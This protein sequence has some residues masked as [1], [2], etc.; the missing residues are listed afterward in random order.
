MNGEKMNQRKLC[1]WI[2]LMHHVQ[3]IL[4]LGSIPG[5]I[6]V[7]PDY[8]LTNIETA[9]V[10][11]W[12]IRIVA[13]LRKGMNTDDVGKRWDFL[14]ANIV[15]KWRFYAMPHALLANLGSNRPKRPY[16]PNPGENKDVLQKVLRIL[17]EGKDGTLPRLFAVNVEDGYEFSRRKK[18]VNPSKSK[19][20]GKQPA[21]KEKVKDDAAP[22]TK[23]KVGRGKKNARSPVPS[24]T[25]PE[26]GN[27]QYVNLSTFSLIMVHLAPVTDIEPPPSFAEDTQDESAMPNSPQATNA[28]RDALMATSISAALRPQNIRSSPGAGTSRDSVK[29][30]SEEDGS[31]VGNLARCGRCAY[32][33]F[34]ARY[35]VQ[36]FNP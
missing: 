35:L 33:I 23:R 21:A 25:D 11:E 2:A 3:G 12:V 7:V 6:G 10:P 4:E 13:S 28:H 15:P 24:Q 26:E 9:N 16:W 14:R 20:K 17:E 19:D 29:P 34:T 31:L 22:T 8:G 30:P 32:L 1:W 27:A 5:A 18:A 36:P